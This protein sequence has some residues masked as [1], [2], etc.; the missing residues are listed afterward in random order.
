[1]SHRWLLAY[2]L[3]NILLWPGIWAVSHFHGPMWLGW[4]LILTGLVMALA[5]GGKEN[6]WFQ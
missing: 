4:T 5:R 3:V 6:G 2:S 1:M